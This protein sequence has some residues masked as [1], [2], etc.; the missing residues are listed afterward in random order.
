MIIRDRQKKEK[1]SEISAGIG[2]FISLHIAT[3][4]DLLWCPNTVDALK[5]S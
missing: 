3:F 2:G 1:E 4:T 5:D